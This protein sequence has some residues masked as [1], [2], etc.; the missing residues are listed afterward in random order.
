MIGLNAA[1][2]TRP[3]PFDNDVVAWRRDPR[4]PN[5]ARP[6]HRCVSKP[7]RS[8][9]PRSEPVGRIPVS[10]MRRRVTE[11]PPG[12][13]QTAQRQFDAPGQTRRPVMALARSRHDSRLSAMLLKPF[14]S[15]PAHIIEFG[16][17]AIRQIPHV[18]SPSTGW[19][20]ASLHARRFGPWT[21]PM[22]LCVGAGPR[23]PMARVNRPCARVDAGLGV[24]AKRGFWAR[25]MGRC[26]RPDAPNRYGNSE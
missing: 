11:T 24:C 3:R 13:Q 21:L 12:R 9:R 19:L 8:H 1:R 18:N 7:R 16:P 4:R 10:L 17:V 23:F 5:V 25:Q 22:S 2:L 26:A 15:G 20:F 14:R 6:I